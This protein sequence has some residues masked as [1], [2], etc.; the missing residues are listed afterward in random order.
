MTEALVSAIARELWRLHGGNETLN[1]LEAELHVS[2]LLGAPP[3]PATPAAVVLPEPAENRTI[4][5]GEIVPWASA[6]RRA[7]SG[8]PKRT[9]GAVRKA[10]KR[11]ERGRAIG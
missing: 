7:S 3:A 2:A 11:N 9:G 4:V 6:A 8:P 1:W 5:D 10:R